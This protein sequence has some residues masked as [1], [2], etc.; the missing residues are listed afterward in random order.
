[1]QAEL[2]FRSFWS[3]S[4]EHRSWHTGLICS[5][6]V[7]ASYLICLKKAIFCGS[8]PSH[9]PAPNCNALFWGVTQRQQLHANSGSE[10]TWLCFPSVFG[11]RG[12]FSF[13]AGHQYQKHLFLIGIENTNKW[14]RDQNPRRFHTKLGNVD[15]KLL[16]TRAQSAFMESIRTAF[17]VAGYCWEICPSK[18][19]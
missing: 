13:V 4:S 14:G 18:F 3:P 9:I 7:Y 10:F 16:S 17:C 12:R 15:L 11:I 2:Y 5:N 19:P 8:F 6:K 1:M